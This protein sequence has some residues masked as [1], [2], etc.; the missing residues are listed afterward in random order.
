MWTQT[1]RAQHSRKGLRYHSYLT[2]VEWAVIARHLPGE[3]RNGRPR[4]W[5]MR[6]VA[7]GIV[8]A[9]LPSSARGV[10]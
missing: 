1:T 6:E 9:A 3:R 4:S 10:Q 2:D 7:S 8:R 5:L